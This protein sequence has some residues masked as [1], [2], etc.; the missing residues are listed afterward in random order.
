MPKEK[1]EEEKFI[2]TKSQIDEIISN[3]TN[4]FILKAKWILLKELKP[5]EEKKEHGK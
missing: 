5:F 4:R 3:M 2:I 1:V